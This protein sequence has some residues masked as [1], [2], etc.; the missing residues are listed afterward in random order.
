MVNLYWFNRWEGQRRPEAPEIISCLA[1]EVHDAGDIV[2]DAIMLQGIEMPALSSGAK[3][4]YSWGKAGVLAMNIAVW[5][6]R[7]EKKK[8]ERRRAGYIKEFNRA[9]FSCPETLSHPANHQRWKIV[10]GRMI[11]VSQSS[12]LSP[13]LSTPANWFLY[14]CLKPINKQI[15]YLFFETYDFR[16]AF[17]GLKTLFLAIY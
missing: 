2:R 11:L 14:L 12:C 10:P 13:A 15:Y 1:V 3:R 8:A 9:E 17:C 4:V 16:G 6:L 5:F 7:A